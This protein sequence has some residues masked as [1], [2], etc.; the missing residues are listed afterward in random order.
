LEL[1]GQT[2][3]PSHVSSRA[4]DSRSSWRDEPSLNVTVSD[5]IFAGLAISRHKQQIVKDFS[6]L[7]QLW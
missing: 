1:T 5:W 4:G 6:N 7:Q 3:S 2:Q